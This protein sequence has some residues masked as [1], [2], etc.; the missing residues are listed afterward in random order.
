MQADRIAGEGIALAALVAAVA[1]LLPPLAAAVAIVWYC[2]QMWEHPVG[3]RWRARCHR[4]FERKLTAE[5][6]LAFLLTG[7][8]GAGVAFVFL[9]I[10]RLMGI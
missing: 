5:D 1:K 8:G 6:R 3:K 10:Y 9:A 2:V 4:V 7:L